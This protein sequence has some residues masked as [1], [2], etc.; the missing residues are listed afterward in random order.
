[1]THPQPLQA[2]LWRIDSP[3]L[4]IAYHA[5]AAAAAAASGDSDKSGT[6][7]TGVEALRV[8]GARARAGLARRYAA[9]L[10][11]FGFSSKARLD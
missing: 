7:G 8:A 3:E 4:W 11:A 9:D 1:V 5:A 6:A 2:V 10:T